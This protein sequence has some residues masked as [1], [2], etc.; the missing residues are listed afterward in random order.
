MEAAGAAGQC[1]GHAMGNALFA[2]RLEHKAWHLAKCQVTDGSDSKYFRAS[3]L[4]RT[5]RRIEI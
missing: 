5:G 3:A 2:M 4:K 1:T